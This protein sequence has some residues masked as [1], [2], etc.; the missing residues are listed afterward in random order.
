MSPVTLGRHME[1]E[2]EVVEG[3]NEGQTIVVKGN[4]SLKTG[5]KV[6]IKG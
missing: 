4:A 1:A 3:L 6:E 5:D 2:Y